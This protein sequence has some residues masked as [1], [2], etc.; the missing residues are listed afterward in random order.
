MGI[1]HIFQSNFNVTID[2]PTETI[3]PTVYLW[4]ANSTY[5]E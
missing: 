4:K 2:E 3:L 1:Y 5:N